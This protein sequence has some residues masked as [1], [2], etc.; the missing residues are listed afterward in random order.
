MGKNFLGDQSHCRVSEREIGILRVCYI[1]ACFSKQ[2]KN[3]PSSL[4]SRC[5]VNHCTVMMI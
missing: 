1:L 2:D 5:D 4:S 3:S